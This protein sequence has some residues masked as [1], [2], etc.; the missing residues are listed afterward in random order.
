[1]PNL[2]QELNRR[3]VFRAVIAYLAVS[4]L[5][6]EVATTILP[7][8]PE[9]PAW[10]ARSIV[11]LLF[12]GFFPTLILA[13]AYELTSKGL[14]RGKQSNAGLPFQS[15]MN[16]IVDF[17]SGGAVVAAIGLFLW[18]PQSANRTPSVAVLPFVNISADAENEY[19]SD[20]LTEMLIHMLAQSR[21]IKVTSR[22]SV[23]ALKGQER[24]VRDIG[25]LLDVAHVLA[26]SVQRS[27]NQLRITAQ[28]I[29]TADGNNIW[30]KT[31]DRTVNDIFAIQ[32]EI[33]SV[34][35]NALRTSLLAKPDDI[36]GVSTENLGAY[37]LFLQAVTVR[38]AATTEALAE[39]EQLLKEALAIDPGFLNAKTEL[40]SVYLEQWDFGFR[41][42]EDAVPDILS[43]TGQVLAER[44]LDSRATALRLMTQFEIALLDGEMEIVSGNVD[45]LLALVDRAPN[46]I[47]ARV[48]LARSFMFL[49][50][51]EGNLEQLRQ[52]TNIDPLRAD[53]YW[54]MSGP[55][56][57]MGDMDGARA[58][59]R[60]SLELN[61]DQVL[62]Y[63][64]LAGISR[65]IGD[66]VGYIDNYLQA[67]RLDPS[68]VELIAPVASHLFTLK[69]VDEG[70]VY[71]RHAIAIGPNHSAVQYAQ[72]M[73]AAVIDDDELIIEAA[74]VLIEGFSGGNRLAG[75]IA[76]VK[77]VLR[78]GIRLGRGDE[79]LEYVIQY[80][81]DFDGV[82]LDSVA[83]HVRVSQV[84]ALPELAHLL[85]AEDVLRL[86][87]DIDEF[88]VSV[89][90]S[91]N[92]NPRYHVDQLLVRGQLEEAIQVYLGDIFTLPPSQRVYDAWLLTSLFRAELAADPR[93]QA[94]LQRSD[95]EFDEIREKVRTF[96]ASLPKD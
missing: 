73:R 18:A 24:D 17:V 52:A 72:L 66:T 32:D 85:P 69:M 51:A 78:S 60:R 20:G 43:L 68:D 83:R 45:K 47:D 14:R 53:I 19:F 38:V 80:L 8:Y 29:D 21:A 23:F 26:G 58:S 5:V 35:A 25:D 7:L 6:V 76:A 65:D 11:S 22:T 56:R 88:Y 81:P 33:A 16:R 48:F 3:N 31:Y 30:S 63:L 62:P 86:I 94:E 10:L 59:I 74:K 41:S 50:D 91:P 55:Q 9:A 70:D 37:D 28:L 2:I 84:L 57:Q 15:R 46:D 79:Y 87:D 39:A 34:V 89:G 71:L 93:I 42:Q 13:W 96:L 1:M 77:N 67:W 40:A 64:A 44:A 27:N 54:K 49:G 95:R 75:I 36:V 82:G 61:P 12:I 4:W 92:E 90:S